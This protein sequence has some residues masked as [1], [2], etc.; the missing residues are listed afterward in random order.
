MSLILLKIF[1]LW[2]VFFSITLFTLYGID[3]SQAQVNGRRIP[4]KTLHF[5]ALAGGFVGGFIG[6]TFFHHKTRKPIFLIILL[7]SLVIH[8]ICWTVFWSVFN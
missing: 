8:L 7:A 1:G 6:R 5:L 2:Y 3:K 4:E